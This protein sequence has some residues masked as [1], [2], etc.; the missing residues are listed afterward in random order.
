MGNSTLHHE[1]V[2]L[3]T[4]LVSQGFPVLISGAAAN[5]LRGLSFETTSAGSPKEPYV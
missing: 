3:F 5:L 4:W 1:K 2:I